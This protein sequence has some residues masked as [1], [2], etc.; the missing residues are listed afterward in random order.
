MENPGYAPSGDEVVTI[1]S[2]TDTVISFHNI[3]L[4]AKVKKADK[5]IL[6]DIRCDIETFCSVT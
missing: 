3:R 2:E 4:T 1:P 5:V 6:D